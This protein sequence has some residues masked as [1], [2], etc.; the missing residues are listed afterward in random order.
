MFGKDLKKSIFQ[1]GWD[2]VL[3]GLETWLSVGYLVNSLSAGC[4]ELKGGRRDE[5]RK[6]GQNVL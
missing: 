2:S 1:S 4:R 3:T 6:A 5:S